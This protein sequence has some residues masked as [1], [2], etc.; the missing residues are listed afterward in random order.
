M[1]VS[2]SYRSY[3]IKCV[4]VIYKSPG[5]IFLHKT[6]TKE[7]LLFVQDFFPYGEVNG[8]KRTGFFR[9]QKVFFLWWR[10]YTLGHCELNKNSKFSVMSQEYHWN[11]FVLS[12][13]PY[14]W[15]KKST[16]VDKFLSC[17]CIHV[18]CIKNLCVAESFVFQCM[19]NG[20]V[21]PGFLWEILA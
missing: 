9:F 3:K 12:I 8:F 7:K 16:I 5:P 11:L 21:L 1:C 14:T 18:E 17:F 6:F 19:V 10:V 15:K 20:T 13:V 4:E 2:E